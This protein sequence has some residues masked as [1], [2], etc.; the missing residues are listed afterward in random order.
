LQGFLSI[1]LGLASDLL[2]VRRTH[3]APPRRWAKM[4]A[5]ETT[6]NP[7]RTRSSWRLLTAALLL[8]TGFLAGQL[9]NLGGP[10]S[11]APQ[12]Q[13]RTVAARGDLASDEKSTI[14]LFQAASPSVVYIT[15]V[16][17]QRDFWSMRVYE[18]PQGAG[19]GFMWDMDGHIVTNFH[20]INGA[21][22]ATVT[23]A[24]QSTWD[25][26]LVGY[27]QEKDL[28]VLRIEAPRGVLR[29]LPLGTSRNLQVGQKVF[30][31]GN[32]FG[33]D[34]T[35]TTGVI[36]ALGREIQ[37]LSRR[38]IR[39][40][41]QTDAAI[42]PGN[43]GGPLLDSAGRLIGVNTMIYSP[44]GASAGVGF[45]IPADTVNWVVPDLINH[46]KLN[47]PTLGVTLANPNQASQLDIEAGALVLEVA[48]GSGGAGAGVRGTR[49]TGRRN[50][51]LGDVIV[52]ID[53]KKIETSDDVAL[54]LERK[55]PGER[56]EVT[57]QRGGRKMKMTI[58]LGES[59]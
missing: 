12:A 26:E 35:L 28:A 10:L 50:I 21:S 4:P 56:T 33:L 43:S 52:E 1:E 20:V 31:I 42:N 19:T 58:V 39:D 34:Q 41:V 8:T 47:R 37:S 36:S 54:A 45:A 55:R 7:T 2:D 59:T 44:S 17:R 11:A 38:P 51:E 40:V 27:A 13:P 24:D 6:M 57:V 15:T 32:P 5:T 49:V 23:L 3:P 48:E 53:G 25:A 9:L 29:P 22:R 16:T 46:G 30:A 14:Q 18:T